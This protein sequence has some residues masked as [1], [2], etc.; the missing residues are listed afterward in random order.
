MTR[1]RCKLFCECRG[2]ARGCVRKARLANSQISHCT[3]GSKG[4][5]LTAEDGSLFS[6]QES[7]GKAF[8]NFVPVRFRGRSGI[9]DQV[10][11]HQELKSFRRNQTLFR[12]NQ[13]L[14]I[15]ASSSPISVGDRINSLESFLFCHTITEPL[16][17]EGTSEGHLVQLPCNEQGHCR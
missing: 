10:H 3:S 15:F 17:L 14:T 1:Q 7:G 8:H 13:T 16:E 6:P 5:Q 12:R 2:G 11:V 9:A 4:P